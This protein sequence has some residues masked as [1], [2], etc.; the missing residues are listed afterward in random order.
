MKFKN[1]V[2]S[3]KNGEVVKKNKTAKTLEV[4]ENRLKNDPK[5]KNYEIPEI[6]KK[7]I[8]N[9]EKV[10][11]V[12]FNSGID[13][14]NRFEV[15]SEKLESEKEGERGKVG[16]NNVKIPKFS[17][18]NN[19]TSSEKLHREPLIEQNKEGFEE[20][21]VNFVKNSENYEVEDNLQLPSQKLSSN[22]PDSKLFA[23]L[24][25]KILRVLM[26]VIN[27]WKPIFESVEFSKQEKKDIEQTFEEA[28]PDIQVNSK[29]AFFSTLLLVLGS[30]VDLSKLTEKNDKENDVKK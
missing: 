11:E 8:E 1:V 23:F 27:K 20:R 16:D 17:E 6:Y 14:N 3:Y 2:I 29:F 5:V 4:L 22:S 28:Y 12:V 13:E 9:S 19:E 10:N 26:T 30:K 15:S 24:I 25:P 21:I 7:N 18:K